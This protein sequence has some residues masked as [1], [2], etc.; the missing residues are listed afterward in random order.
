MQQT[1]LT[2]NHRARAWKWAFASFV[3]TVCVWIAF[4]WPLP[5]LLK[6]GIPHTAMSPPNQRVVYMVPGDHLQL[7]YHFWLAGDMIRGGTPPFRNL[8]EFNIGDDQA[9]RRVGPYYFPFSFLYWAGESLGGR[10][11]GW[12]VTGFLTLWL[13]YLLTCLLARRYT[14]SDMVAFF[15]A[16]PGIA[17]PV[18]WIN[19]LGG[20]P[21]GFALMWCPA[22]LLGLDLAIRDGHVGGGFLAGL[23]LL[24]ASWTDSHVF[25]FCAL[26]APAWSCVVFLQREQFKPWGNTIRDLVVALL[27]A[28]IL[29]GSALFINRLFMSQSATDLMTRGGRLPQEAMLF[30]PQWRGLFQHLADGTSSQIY[31]GWCVMIGM[32]VAVALSLLSRSTRT[33]LLA[34]E[35]RSTT[36]TVFFLL[37]AVAGIALLALGPRGP[38][39]GLAFRAARKL[40]PPYT[41]IRQPAKIFCLVP[42]LLA[43]LTAVAWTQI[44]VFVPARWVAVLLPL[45]ALLLVTEYRYP[46]RPGVCLLDADQATYAAVA[47]DAVAHQVSPHALVIPL[48]PGDSHWTSLYQYY[49]SLYR[50]RMVN[51]YHP[52]V[53]RDYMTNVFQ[54][55]E[56]VNKGRVDEAQLA[57]LQAAGVDQ[58]ILHENAF[59]EKVSPFPVGDTLRRLL[60]NP[61]LRWLAQSNGVWAF[62]I[63]PP[64][65]P[66]QEIHPAPRLPFLFPTRFWEVER[67]STQ[68][69]GVV[70]DPDASSGLALRLTP[71]SGRI[72]TGSVGAA[73]DKRLMWLMRVRG[74]GTLVP[75]TVEAGT[76]S[77]G[78]AVKVNAPHWQ[79][80]T[81]P[82]DMRSSYAMLAASLAV[83]NGHV[84]VDLVVLAGG[85]WKPMAV[86]ESVHLPAASFFHA[87]YTD[88]ETLRVVLQPVRDPADIVFY[89]WRFP[90]EPGRYGL[91]MAYICAAPPGTV[92]GELVCDDRSGQVVVAT[93]TA[94]APATGIVARANNLPARIG[95]RYAGQAKVEI[96]ELKLSRL[97]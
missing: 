7:L 59:P 32:A 74:A 27:P 45:W 38:E 51:G 88:P 44:R 66:P 64:G 37:A 20:S 53:S 40:I 90:L 15:A 17:M 63:E 93:V 96:A 31:L 11:F 80:M 65:L 5:T 29:A 39:D 56:S 10:A 69:Q 6:K 13:A 47:K 55:L 83:T 8:Y 43:I 1:Y 77:N 22:M 50:I 54:R 36:I 72:E 58:I 79:W 21:F 70:E 2:L 18:Y 4:T 25:F 84:D 73:L 75:G 67:L 16:L 19:L 12:N 78:Q 42:S 48:W 26:M 46:L 62:R 76:N 60:Q 9:T 23:S 95:F 91:D 28:G 68:G 89:G 49:A 94:G 92:L 24:F 85:P 33:R 97:K 34:R 87:G 14:P 41:M 82:V 61:R 30:S 52:F 3:V 57:W 35:M 71:A 81:A 86:G